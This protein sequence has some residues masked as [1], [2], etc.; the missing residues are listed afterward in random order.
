[1]NV[2]N[3]RLVLEKLSELKGYAFL[4]AKNIEFHSKE[5]NWKVCK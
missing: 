2:K 5:I 3:I 1:M 4:K